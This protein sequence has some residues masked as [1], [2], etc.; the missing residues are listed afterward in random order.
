M[1]TWG[2][3]AMAVSSA[4]WLSSGGPAIL[5]GADLRPPGE[6]LELEDLVAPWA[7]PGAGPASAGDSNA[8]A[9][10]LRK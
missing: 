3:A 2:T 6:L 8:A 9:R 7:P 5:V 10:T 4:V 1:L